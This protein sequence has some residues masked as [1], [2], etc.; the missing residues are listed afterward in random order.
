MR[1]LRTPL[2][3]FVVALALTWMLWP[4]SNEIA[5]DASSVQSAE[6]RP[7]EELEAAPATIAERTTERKIDD[8]Q[9][10]LR[11]ILRDGTSPKNATFY[12]KDKNGDKNYNSTTAST[13]ISREGGQLECMVYADGYWSDVLQLND[14]ERQAEDEALLQTKIESGQALI[15][16]QLPNNATSNW[17]CQAH[18]NKKL[19]G[20]EWASARKG[21]IFSQSELSK[22]SAFSQ[23][24][25]LNFAALPPGIWSFEIQVEGFPITRLSAEIKPGQRV[26]LIAN[27]SFGAR[28]SGRVV[29]I[30][31]QPIAEAKALLVMADYQNV[32]ELLSDKEQVLSLAVDGGITESDENGYFEIGPVEAD[33]YIA[34]VHHEL[35]QNWSSDKFP[36]AS[37]GEHQLGEVILSQGNILNVQVVNAIT[38]EPIQNASVEWFSGNDFQQIAISSLLPWKTAESKTDQDGNT[39]I[40]NLPFGELSVR[41]GRDG[42]SWTSSALSKSALDAGEIVLALFPSI[43]VGGRVVNMLDGTPLADIEVR[44]FHPGSGL[45]SNL[46]AGQGSSPTEPIADTNESGEFLL[47]GLREGQ[48]RIR[49]S[50]EDWASQTQDI[51]ILANKPAPFVE[52]RLSKGAQLLVKL[53]DAQGIPDE[54]GLINLL[55]FGDSSASMPRSRKTNARG[56]VTFEHL[57]PGNYQVQ[58]FPSGSEMQ[59]V[60]AAM[61]KL[62][63]LQ[64]TSTFI[65]IEENKFH[66]LTL[67]GLVNRCDIEGFV[68]CGENPR[69]GLT[70]MLNSLTGVQSATTDETGFYEIHGVAEGDYML[71]VGSLGIAGGSGWYSNMVVSGSGVIE[72]NID[73][74]LTQVKVNVRAAVDGAPLAKIPVMLRPMNGTPGGGYRNSDM[75][76]EVLFEFTTPGN[77]AVCVGNAAMPLLGGGTTYSSELV[78]NV[79][80]LYDQAVSVDVNL[81]QASSITVRVIDSNG[82]PVSGAGVFPLSAEGQAI[83][84]FSLRTTDAN[85]EIKLSSLPN[86]A[87]QLIARHPVLG[88]NV[89]AVDLQM[90]DNPPTQIQ[91]EAGCLIRVQVVDDQGQA[92][93]GIAA[94]V[95]NQSGSPIS[96]LLY[97]NQMMEYSANMM[98]GNEQKLGP[99]RPGKYVLL[100]SNLNGDNMRQPLLI[101]AGVPEQRLTI[102]FAP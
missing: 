64:I 57:N 71:M 21:Y 51:E 46:T 70:V 95:L 73:L 58:G 20:E 66:E 83:T 29:D 23:Q 34:V 44:A 10:L 94:V 91:L 2:L 35:F 4:H 74:P 84:Q 22:R 79:E 9:L 49:A 81:N 98:S 8:T 67:G 90:G 41:A 75:N 55:N 99:M 17:T 47:N 78:E 48:W 30:K 61:G 28:V 68:Y 69:G 72:K 93:P 53:L 12:W 26:E 37:R 39:L 52:F 45:I 25:E 76:G 16:L 102:E 18:W 85:G 36:L 60:G 100:L 63:G 89:I 42:F 38:Q 3:L 43:S 6:H 87:I 27:L 33:K 11:A 97:G 24:G 88:E 5:Q 82:S 40:E 59:L 80:V 13:T 62:G 19:D 86:Q 14:A 32:L 65:D 77:Y 56:E 101:E 1:N 15:K 7:N 92:Q 54:N 96:S 31:G 50:S